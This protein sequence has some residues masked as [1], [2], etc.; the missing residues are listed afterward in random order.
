MLPHAKKA[1]MVIMKNVWGNATQVIVNV[2]I[3]VIVTIPHVMIDVHVTI[4]AHGDVHADFSNATPFA[5]TLLI[6]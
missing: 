4:N 6:R 3:F 5:K 2:E 1:V